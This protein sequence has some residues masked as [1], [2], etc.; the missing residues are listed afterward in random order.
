MLVV[1]KKDNLVVIKHKSGKIIKEFDFVDNNCLSFSDGTIIRFSGEDA[2]I[3]QLGTSHISKKNYGDGH[4]VYMGVDV[5]WFV[6]G[7]VVVRG[8]KI[9]WL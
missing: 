1:F 7:E 9:P 3:F 4:V 5:K 6:Y 8:Y 2:D